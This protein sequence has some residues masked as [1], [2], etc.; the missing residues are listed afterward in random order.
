ME[1]WI[2]STFCWSTT[3]YLKKIGQKIWKWTLA[4][5][6]LW[7]EKI[8]SGWK[9]L[10]KTNFGWKNWSGKFGAITS[11][12]DKVFMIHISP[13]EAPSLS[14]ASI[15]P[16]TWWSKNMRCDSLYSVF[17]ATVVKKDSPSQPCWCPALSSTLFCGIAQRC[18][19]RPCDGW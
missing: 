19:I 2:W 15:V 3:I 13:L 17:K 8:G 11:L 4:W 7:V 5:C 12:H 9:K 6:T 14:I 16:V 18:C 10:G 1:H